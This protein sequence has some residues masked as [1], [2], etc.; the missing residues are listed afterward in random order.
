MK[1]T[2][3]KFGTLIVTLSPLTWYIS[4]NASQRYCFITIL[5]LL[6][7]VI[8]IVGD[9]VD[10]I[11]IIIL[12]T[13][14]HCLSINVNDLAMFAQLPLPAAYGMG[15]P[16]STSPVSL[17]CFPSLSR[18]SGVRLRKRVNTLAVSRLSS[19]SWCWTMWPWRPRNN[20]GCALMWQ[21]ATRLS[22]RTL[23][24]ALFRSVGGNEGN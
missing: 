13:P 16:S 22:S 15:L 3:I 6:I 5:S 1:P 19:A 23:R 20:G 7:I 11:F 4:W 17:T 24:S 14:I 10:T 18:S 21:V 12:G 2:L 9:V 8:F